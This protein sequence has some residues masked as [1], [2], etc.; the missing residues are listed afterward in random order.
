MCLCVWE[1]SLGDLVSCSKSSGNKLPETVGGA[2]HSLWDDW[3]REWSLPRW[4]QLEAEG[5][6]GRLGRPGWPDRARLIKQDLGEGRPGR[7][8]LAGGG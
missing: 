4:L 5:R 1:C 8:V 6:G 2:L 3:C 7:V